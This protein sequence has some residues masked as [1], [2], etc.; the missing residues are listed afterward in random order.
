MTPHTLECGT[1]DENTGKHV[2]RKQRTYGW[3]YETEFSSVKGNT[4][5]WQSA[6]IHT[7]F[8]GTSL[9]IDPQHHVVMMILSNRLHPHGAPNSEKIIDFRKKLADLTAQYIAQRERTNIH[10]NHVTTNANPN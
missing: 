3:D 9:L 7:G 8:T 1:Y 10:P 5:F 4:T 2:G 6:I